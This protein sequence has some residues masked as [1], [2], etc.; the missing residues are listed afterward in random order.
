MT[1]SVSYDMPFYLRLLSSMSGRRSNTI[2]ARVLRPSWLLFV[3]L[4]TGAYRN[5]SSNIL[6][7]G[8]L[9]NMFRQ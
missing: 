5:K 2:L 8:S 6:L 3:F 9:L 4:L 1:V 7:F